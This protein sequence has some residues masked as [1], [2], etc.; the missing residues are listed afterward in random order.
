[1]KNEFDSN[2]TSKITIL[3]VLLV[4]V[5]S[6]TGKSDGNISSNNHS[7]IFTQEEREWLE[8]HPVITVA[9]DPTFAPVEYYDSDGIL[10]GIAPDFLEILEEK[11]EV[12]FQFIRM[13]NWSVILDEIRAHRIDM[14]GAA[15]PSPQRLE[16]LYFSDPHT[17]NP[18]I[19]INLQGA[20]ENLTMDQLEGMKV[21]SVV[22]YVWSDYLEEEHPELD[23]RLVPDVHS[24]LQSVSYG[25]LD[26]FLINSAVAS[27]AIEEGG[28]TNLHLAGETGWTTPLC[29]A[30]WDPVLAGIMSKGLRM[31]SEQEKNEIFSKWISLSVSHPFYTKTVFWRIFAI[32]LVFLLLVLLFVIGW[33][34]SLRR[35]VIQRTYELEAELAEKLR[36]EVQFR[37]SQKM[38]AIGEL[39]GG[40]AHDFNNILQAITGTVSLAEMKLS[41]NDPVF[42]NLQE[43]QKATDRA[44]LLTKQL[45]AFGGR[46]TLRMGIVD[47]A[48]LIQNLV[49]MISRI[50]KETIVVDLSLDKD[51]L[52]ISADKSQ[53]E[54]VLINLCI[55][56]RDA[57]SNGGKLSI[58]A[59][60]VTLK[61]EFV[62]DNPL[63]KEGD[64]VLITVSDTGEGMSEEVMVRIFE[65]FFT[66]KEIYK[67]TGLGLSSVHGIVN[68]HKG[69]V[70][71]ESSLGVGSSFR[72][73]LP[74]L[75]DVK[76]VLEKVLDRSITSS[77]HAE[78]I[79]LAEDET[80]VRTMFTE[81][82]KSVGFTV[83]V[84][85][86]G[87][88]AVDLLESNNAEI[89]VAIL[90]IVMPGMSGSRIGEIIQKKYPHIKV[91]YT[92]G[93]SNREF[94][95]REIEA[96]DLRILAK[97]FHP[98]DLLAAI[99]ECLD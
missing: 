56:A 58:T 62:I 90:D 12:E 67:G 84:A 36:L 87:L 55:N 66:T 15:A 14:L 81:I 93:Y 47:V 82:L 1:M 9:P 37:K 18:S 73:Y 25:E 45:L 17:I 78:T 72:I 19:I 68:Q 28:Y 48:S 99:R 46:Q 76:A 5:L 22:G 77:G 43:I 59:E 83:L 98:I 65:P 20:D 42:D 3:L 30:S 96:G 89:S 13:E 51:L 49:S 38:E 63:A 44:A 39:A 7:D 21:G 85:S 70:N 75:K 34:R 16:F 94:R 88:E 91:I 23:V 50:I 57:M 27:F 54:Q 31:I 52:C 86:N 41:H 33:N 80:L 8:C 79:L 29:F 92:T 40:V 95:D 69:I 97:P 60:N 2:F 74:A 10:R 26:V 11:L 71:V 32:I 6:C 24:G 64:Y 35:E 53:I 61:E 4:T